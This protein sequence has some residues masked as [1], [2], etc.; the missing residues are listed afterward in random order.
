MPRP[1]SRSLTDHELSILQI[2]WAVPHL[3]VSE[4]IQ[5]IDKTPKPAY[6]SLLTAVQ[7]LEKKGVLAR[8][9]DGQAHRYY[10]LLKKSEYRQKSIKSLLHKVF[11]GNAYD[12]AV[13]LFKSE[14]L[15]AQDREKIKKLLESL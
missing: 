10:P 13:N 11:D 9:K 15:D 5:R 12:L 14:E 7:A 2:L 6:T 8:E 1:S 4:I 3:T